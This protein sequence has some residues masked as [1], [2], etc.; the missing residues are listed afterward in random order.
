M[1][2]ERMKTLLAQVQQEKQAL[3]GYDIHSKA[4]TT[5]DQPLSDLQTQQL[6]RSIKQMAGV[7]VGIGATLRGFHGL[8][9]LMQEQNPAVP[10]RVV[11][12]PVVMP[13]AR[14]KTVKRATSS[15]ADI[16]GLPGGLPALLLGGPLSVY[17][18]WKGVDMVLDKYRKK[19]QQDKLEDAKTQYEQALLGSYK[20][21][22]DTNLNQVFI[23]VKQAEDD[24]ATWLAKKVNDHVIPSS[25]KQLYGTYALATMPLSYALIDAHMK[26]TSPRAILNDAVQERARQ[27]ALTQP[28]QI[29]AY[30]ADD[31]ENQP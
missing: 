15:I 18:G 13:D 26:R 3:F 24:W 16:A 20:K 1:N 19:T 25:A 29:Y 11:D 27:R 21:A 10:P 5:A 12:L 22:V 8:S 6:I 2:L 23:A 7:G 4:P 9:N 28:A 31:E 14:K 30:R 17:G